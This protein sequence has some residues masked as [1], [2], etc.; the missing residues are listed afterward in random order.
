MMIVIFLLILFGV[1]GFAGNALYQG[2]SI[3]NLILGYIMWLLTLLIYQDFAITLHDEAKEGI[4]EQLYMSPY[5]YNKISV[6][7]LFSSFFL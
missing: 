3:D 6:L 4:L 7:R 1:K 5:G 2:N